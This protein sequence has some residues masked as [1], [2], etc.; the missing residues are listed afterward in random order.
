MG[1]GLIVVMI[2]SIGGTC[3]RVWVRVWVRVNKT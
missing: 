2:F 3:G 1:K